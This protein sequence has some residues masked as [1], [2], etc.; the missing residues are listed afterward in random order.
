MKTAVQKEIV[1]IRHVHF[2]DLGSFE[3]KFTTLGFRIRYV[4]ATSEDLYSIDFQHPDVLAVLGGPIGVYEQEK[5][6]F[7]RRELEVLRN[8]IAARLPTLGI[9]LGCQ[10]IA[11]ALGGAVHPGNGKEIGW[12]AVKLTEAGWSSP[13]SHLGAP[14]TRVLHWHGDT[15]TLPN[16]AQLLASTDQYV[17]QAFS[18]GD[19]VLALQ[20]H[21]EV[22]RA[23]LE[24]WFVGH[25]CEIGQTPGVSLAQLRTDTG[26]EAPKLSSAAH[27]VLTDWLA[28][29]GTT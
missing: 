12:G 28:R 24:D 15:F 16:G 6:P 23:G 10:L 26:R 27:K 13:L 1:A 7:L 17:H 29:A 20:F 2:E 14:G 3:S 11:E 18:I 8:R 22:T 4:E 5:Y 21:L 19:H 9:C 25:A